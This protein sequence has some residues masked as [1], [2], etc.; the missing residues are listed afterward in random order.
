MLTSAICRNI[1]AA[2]RVEGVPAPKLI[3]PGDFFAK[4]TRSATFFAGCDGVTSKM[5]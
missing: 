3:F 4:E 5:L 2:M 1:S